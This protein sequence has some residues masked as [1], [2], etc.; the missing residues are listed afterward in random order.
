MVAYSS[1]SLNQ[2]RELSSGFKS[3]SYRQLPRQARPHAG[4][5]HPNL[6]NCQPNIISK[7]AQTSAFLVPTLSVLGLT[8]GRNDLDHNSYF[9]S[10]IT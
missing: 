9:Y 6:V 10:Q 2:G 1:V 5:L 8:F 7:S 3:R 4:W